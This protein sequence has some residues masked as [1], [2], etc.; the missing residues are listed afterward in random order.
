MIGNSTMLIL[1]QVFKTSKASSW[2]ARN[3]SL[4]ALSKI[5]SWKST[6][7]VT[8]TIPPREV[9]QP[10]KLSSHL[11]WKFSRNVRDQVL[12]IIPLDDATELMDYL[13]NLNIWDMRTNFLR[14]TIFDFE[15][16]FELTEKINKFSEFSKN[17]VPKSN[18]LMNEIKNSEVHSTQLSYFSIVKI[19]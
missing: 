12:T 16:Q 3:S 6:L 1:K 19:W 7:S 10:R 4:M 13:T 14:S 15:G 9:Y 11:A 2:N 17:Q 8:R 18:F 5:W